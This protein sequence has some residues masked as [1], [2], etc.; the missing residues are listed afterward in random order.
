MKLGN[1]DNCAVTSLYTHGLESKSDFPSL[2]S[3]IRVT[4]R[5]THSSKF[6]LALFLVQGRISHRHFLSRLGK[7]RP[8][9]IEPLLG[10]GE[11]ANYSLE[12]Y[13]EGDGSVK[14]TCSINGH[15]KYN[16]LNNQHSKITCI[17][18]LYVKCVAFVACAAYLWHSDVIIFLVL[19][20]VN[21]VYGNQ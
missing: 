19:Q 18:Y 9:I 5:V 13:L 17:Q 2:F 8:S 10:Y 6:I 16:C 14:Q 11:N 20:I 12:Q 15:G 4:L 7:T 1:I 21:K 3:V